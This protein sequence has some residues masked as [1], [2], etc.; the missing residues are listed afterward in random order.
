MKVKLDTAWTERL[1]LR[2]EGAR[3]HAEGAK[4]YAEGAKLYA[5][6]NKLHAEGAKRYAEGAKRY[7]EGDLVF[8]NAVITQAGKDALIE[9]TGAGCIVNGVM[10]FLTHA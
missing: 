7:A 5:E 6:G 8:I 10:E 1:K 9:W 4:L 2:A 3:L